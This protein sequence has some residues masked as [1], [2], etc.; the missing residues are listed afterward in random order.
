M[1]RPP[2]I[3]DLES[4]E[5]DEQIDRLVGIILAVIV[6]LLCA[7]VLGFVYQLAG[8]LVAD[9]LSVLWEILK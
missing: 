7:F 3:D 8:P 1:N 5:S 2:W 4:D 9:A 6:A